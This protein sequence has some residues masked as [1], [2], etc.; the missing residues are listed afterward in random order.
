MAD[1]GMPGFILIAIVALLLFGPKKLPELG[2]AFG[3]TIKEF[4]SGVNGLMNDEPTNNKRVPVKE[5]GESISR[6]EE[7]LPE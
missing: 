5:S 6:Q 1:I 3:R 2:H 7:Q 4:K